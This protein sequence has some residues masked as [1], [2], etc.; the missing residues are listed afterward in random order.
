MA[1][2]IYEQTRVSLQSFSSI[3]F[4]QTQ[5]LSS[6]RSKDMV[7]TIRNEVETDT[8]TYERTRALVQKFS[9]IDFRQAE[10]L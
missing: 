8:E 2:E 3:Y 1:R 10:L 4:K 7:V 5:L 9:R 6:A